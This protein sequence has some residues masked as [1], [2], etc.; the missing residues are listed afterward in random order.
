LVR[1]IYDWEIFENE[2]KVSGS[3]SCLISIATATEK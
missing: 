3:I 1:Y 2:P